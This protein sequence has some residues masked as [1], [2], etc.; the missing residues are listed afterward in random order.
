MSNNQKWELFAIGL[1]ALDRLKMLH[2]DLNL[3]LES[4]RHQLELMN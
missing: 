2:E 3:Q 4:A 1:E